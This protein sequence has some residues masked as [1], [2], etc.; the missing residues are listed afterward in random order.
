MAA[1]GGHWQ[2]GS[3]REGSPP[4]FRCM[5]ALAHGWHWAR[6][7]FWPE[8]VLV[9]VHDSAYRMLAHYEYADQSPEEGTYVRA[10]N[11]GVPT[12]P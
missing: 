8:A 2:A 7:L 6:G 1:V 11:Y 5:N 4:G 10:Y 3:E 9:V 12:V